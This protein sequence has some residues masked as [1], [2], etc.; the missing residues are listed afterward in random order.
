MGLYAE[1]LFLLMGDRGLILEFGDEI[2]R[3]V[4][5]K[6]RR[7]ALAIHGNPMEGII[8]IVPTYRSLLVYYNPRVLPIEALRRRLTHLEQGLQLTPFPEPIVTRIPVAYGGE[9]G[10][11]LKY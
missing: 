8:E 10:P 3:E 9:Y 1:T 2:S 6:V 7:M 5:D 11:D 4:N